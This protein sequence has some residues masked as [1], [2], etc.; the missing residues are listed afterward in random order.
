MTTMSAV[1]MLCYITQA[2]LIRNVI[3]IKSRQS[4]LCSSQSYQLTWLAS[5]KTASKQEKKEQ[6]IR[7]PDPEPNE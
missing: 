6:A 3:P 4:N 2:R 1:A 7:N 5:M